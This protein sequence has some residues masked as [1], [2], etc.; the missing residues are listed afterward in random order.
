MRQRLWIALGLCWVLGGAAWGVWTNERILSG[1]QTVFLELAPVDPRS[2][3][4]GDYMVLNYALNASII[5]KQSRDDGYAVVRLDAQRIA[6]LV[7][8]HADLS[9]EGS[10]LKPDELV[11]RYRV[12]NHRVQIAT[13]AFFFQEGQEPL[14]RNARFGEF[15]LSSNGEP[16]L[17]ALRDADLKKL[18]ENRF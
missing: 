9:P 5:Q 10:S 16:R 13:N 18:G 12:R 3:M 4:Q 8:T 1:G 14:F 15:R 11:I 17:V 7:R 6:R 2:L